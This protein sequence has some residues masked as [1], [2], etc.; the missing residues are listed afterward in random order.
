MTKAGDGNFFVTVTDIG[1]TNAP[2]DDDFHLACPG[3]NNDESEESLELENV[4]LDQPEHT[5]SLIHI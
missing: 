3:S 1:K 4:A 2:L 5:L